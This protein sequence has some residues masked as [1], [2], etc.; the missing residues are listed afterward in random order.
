MRKKN[1]KFRRLGRFTDYR[2]TR[3]LDKNPLFITFSITDLSPIIEEWA[4]L[5][6]E[7][8]PKKPKIKPYVKW[9][10]QQQNNLLIHKPVKCTMI[11]DWNKVSLFDISKLCCTPTRYLQYRF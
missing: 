10:R 2:F 1:K 9:K 4:K 6:S 11:V 5:L 7:S 8:Q 3:H